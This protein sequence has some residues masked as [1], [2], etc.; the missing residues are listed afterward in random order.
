VGGDVNEAIKIGGFLRESLAEVVVQDKCYSACFMAIVGTVKVYAGIP[1]GKVGIHRI[2][3]DQEALKQT[4]IK[5]YEA[6]Y[7]K[8]KKGARTYFYE[9]DVPTPIVEEVFAISSD[10]IYFLNDSELRFLN[11]HPAYDEWIKARCPNSLSKVEQS[12][13]NKYVSSGYKNGQFS[14]GY[15]KYLTS[16][17]NDY[18]QCVDTVRWGQFK[19]TITKY[20][21]KAN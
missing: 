19:K 9:M 16:K 17:H 5:E 20:L 10:D 21:E 1:F 18:E 6:S 7:N 11:T 14:D 12:D 2:F 15:I 8:I 3:H 13:F 4:E